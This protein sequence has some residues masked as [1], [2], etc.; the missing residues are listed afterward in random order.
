MKIRQS[1]RHFATKQA[2]Q[3]PGLRAA[4]TRALVSLHTRVFLERADPEHRDERRDHLDGLFAATTAMYLA[5]LQ[6]GYDE[7]TAREITHIVANFDFYNH[8][9]TEMMEFPGSELDTHYERYRSFF[10]AH[11]V[12][13]DNPLGTFLPPGGL[14]EAPATPERLDEAAY[15]S[16]EGGYADDVYVEAEDGE[17][18]KGGGDEP[19][20]V[21][22]SRAPGADS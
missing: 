1:I 6:D 2:L 17:V 11:G 9:W 5:A 13:I 19:E 12:A 7:A 20:D 21:D 16:A 18:R 14:P 4:T 3:I 22:P 10:E 15:E 8:G